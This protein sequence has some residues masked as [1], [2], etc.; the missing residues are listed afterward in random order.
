MPRTAT[1]MPRRSCPPCRA[2]AAAAQIAGFSFSTD[3][4]SIE[5]ITR[6][7]TQWGATPSESQLRSLAAAT[8][9]MPGVQAVPCD[10]GGSR[11]R[12]GLVLDSAAGAIPPEATLP[13]VQSLPVM[14]VA[15][16]VP[17]ASAAPAAPMSPDRPV[18]PSNRFRAFGVRHR[19]QVR[20][21]H[22]PR[23]RSAWGT[24]PSESELRS[25]AQA[26]P[27]AEGVQSIALDG[28]LP[29][30][31]GLPRFRRRRF[32]RTAMIRRR[33]AARSRRGDAVFDDGR[34]A[35]V[36]VLRRHAA[37][38]GVRGDAGRLVCR[39]PSF[40]ASAFRISRR[41]RSTCRRS[42]AISRSSA[43]ASTGSSSSGSTTP[44][45]RR[46][47]SAVID[48]LSF[49]YAHEN[50]NVHRAAHQLAARATDAYEAA[51]ETVRRFLNA[52][53][54][55]GDRLRP[56]ND[57]RDQPDRAELGAP[58]HRQGRRDRHHLARAPRQHRPLADALPGEGGEA[59]R[60][61]GGRFRPG[62]PR[63][64]RAPARSQ[65]QARLVLARL[66][67]A[68]RRSRPAQR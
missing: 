15:S 55:E 46:S 47:R 29:S 18:A 52:K 58:Q 17:A 61:A 62:A 59:A 51:R 25:M 60:R 28:S 49:F 54:D 31:P 33:A 22:E 12:P 6:D 9:A 63:R 7:L 10:G 40:R 8:P 23:L 67:R 14:P 16:V 11:S 5:A 41:S 68:G 57:R 2:C 39:R 65:D 35:V 44:R 42:G 19:P 64:I 48:R 34:P 38:R 3:V 4:R 56:R 43:R 26:A 53:L 36:R 20:R 45:R 21:G 13:G 37:A 24:T 1:A 27:A 32:R 50:S 30:M 66:E